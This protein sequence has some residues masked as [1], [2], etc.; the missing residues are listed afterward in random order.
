MPVE[1]KARLML[2][3]TKEKAEAIIAELKKGADFAKLAARDSKDPSGKQGGDLGWFNL[4]SMVKPFSD[5]VAK[6]KKGETTQAPVETQYG[7]HV[8]QLEDT[9]SPTV[10]AYEDVK[11]QVEQ[12]TQRKK[13][14]AYLDQLRKNAKIQITE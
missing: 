14:Q 11:P 9:R 12:L 10:P 5:A 2:V 13:V 6:L 3:D 4:Q 1:Y 8:I 7:W